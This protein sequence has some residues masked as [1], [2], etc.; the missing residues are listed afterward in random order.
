[1][2]LSIQTRSLGDG[3]F[4]GVVRDCNG[5]EV[6][7]TDVCPGRREA[8]WAASGLRDCLQATGYAAPMQRRPQL[9]LVWSRP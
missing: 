4:V 9:R 6:R 7:R 8:F 1:M 5:H 3:L 2:I